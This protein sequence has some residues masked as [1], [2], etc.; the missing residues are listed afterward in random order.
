MRREY[1][2]V[3][4]AITLPG[5]RIAF[6]HGVPGPW[7]E[8]CRAI[9]DMKRIDYHPVLQE[10]GHPNEA[11]LAWT[12]QNSAPCAVFESERP[13]SHWSELLM[14]AERLCPE[15]RLIPIEQEQ[16]AQMFG[17]CHELCGEDGFGWSCRLLMIDMV[18]RQDGSIRMD[19]LRRKFTSGDNLDHA[20]R[21]IA[22]IMSMLAARLERQRSIGSKY[23]VGNA[24]TAADIYWT[25]FSNLVAPMD[26]ADCPMPDYYRDWGNGCIAR[27]GCEVPGILIEHRQFVLK[28]HW[29]L[30]MWF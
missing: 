3:E 23:L 9:F 14:L 8:A 18:E 13:R 21:R 4:Q 24:L 25:T 7:G 30:P 2:T 1:I 22:S 15:P 29:D 20:A 17:I 16:R 26:H 27:A 28:T 19:L 6:T 10:G 12:G 11:L 5:L